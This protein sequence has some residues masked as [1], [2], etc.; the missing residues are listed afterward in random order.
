M[1]S[2]SSSGHHRVCADCIGRHRLIEK[3]SVGAGNLPFTYADRGHIE[4]G[5]R[6]ADKIMISNGC[7][8]HSFPVALRLLYTDSVHTRRM[9]EIERTEGKSPLKTV[10][11]EPKLS[12]DTCKLHSTG[13]T[14]GRSESRLLQNHITHSSSPREEQYDRFRLPAES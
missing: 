3:S 14:R 6:S 12:L 2:A 5:S 8:F 13:N 11:S 1:D 4:S 7:V 9:R 10:I